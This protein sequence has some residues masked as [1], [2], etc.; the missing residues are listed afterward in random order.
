MRRIRKIFV[1]GMALIPIVCVLALAVSGFVVHR[2]KPYILGPD[3]VKNE[4]DCILVPG[5]LVYGDRPSAML[6]DRLDRA[7]AL[8]RSGVSDRLL[9]SGD[10]GR[11]EYDEVNAM[12]QYVVSQGVPA[13]CVFMD[14][15]GFSTYESMYRAR[16]VFE[17]RSVLIVTQTYHLYRAVYDARRLGLDARGVTAMPNTYTFQTYNDLREILA[18]D[19]DFIYTVFKPKPTCLGDPIPISLSGTLTDDRPGT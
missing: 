15:A 3:A 1:F 16:D 18:R 14:H 13:D 17:V 8:Y 6:Q 12:K 19:K 10:H 11:V 4:Y 2:A 9:V 7:V 5:C